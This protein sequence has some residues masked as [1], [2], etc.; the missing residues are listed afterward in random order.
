[1][2]VNR[3]SIGAGN[4]VDSNPLFNAEDVSAGWMDVAIDGGYVVQVVILA[5][6]TASISPV[7]DLAGDVDYIMNFSEFGTV[8]QLLLPD[9]C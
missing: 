4:V 8:G 1:M 3:Y 9:G 7:P 6:G 5:K 2:L